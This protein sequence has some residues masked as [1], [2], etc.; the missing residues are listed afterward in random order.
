LRKTRFPTLYIHHNEHYGCPQG[1]VSE[2]P[3]G[4][5]HQTT[6]TKNKATKRRKSMI[7]CVSSLRVPCTRAC[8]THKHVYATRTVTHACGFRCKLLKEGSRR[9]KIAL[10][11]CNVP[12]NQ[13]YSTQKARDK[14]KNKRK[15]KQRRWELLRISCRLVLRQNMG[16]KRPQKQ[17]LPA[18]SPETT[19]K[20]LRILY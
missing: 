3:K 5:T 11:A 2:R 12:S 17:P 10:Y 19:P 7:V 18:Y 14:H 20:E 15:H 1:L 13:Q 4:A 6:E 16:Q 9:L 8:S